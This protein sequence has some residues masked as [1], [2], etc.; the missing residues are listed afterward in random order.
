MRKIFYILMILIGS[1]TLLYLGGC[2]Q[3]KTV[4]EDHKIEFKIEDKEFGHTT[5]LNYLVTN[6]VS[7]IGDRLFLSVDDHSPSKMANKVVEFNRKTQKSN[8]LFTTTFERSSIQGLKANKDW[9]V[10]I[11]SDELGGQMN[12]YVMNLST[13]EIESIKKNNTSETLSDTLELT[14]HRAVWISH[15]EEKDATHIYMKDLKKKQTKKL[16][17]LDSMNNAHLSVHNDKLL[18]FNKDNGKQQAYI[19]NLTTE[20]LKKIPLNQSLINNSQLI[21]DHQFVYE[22]A[23]TDS[24]GTI[25]KNQLIFYDINTKQSKLIKNTDSDIGSIVIDDH[26][27]FFVETDEPKKSGYTILKEKNDSIK[28][29]GS[30][31]KENHF[32][33]TFDHGL[34]LLNFQNAQRNNQKLTITSK[35]P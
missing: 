18:F 32:H 19:Y 3:K 24:E 30:L 8:I 23:F 26:N 5:M 11:D 10:W 6:S 34:Y 15:D 20:S 22:K 2:S 21:N 31:K 35:L 29:I 12:Y 25:N 17:K 33:L 28:K 4:S 9:V 13:Q 1:V 14:G 16:F 7:A 27:R